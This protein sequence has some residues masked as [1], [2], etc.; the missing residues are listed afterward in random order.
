[1]T[2]RADAEAEAAA[3]M[4]ATLEDALDPFA[5]LADVFGDADD[6]EDADDGVAPLDPDMVACAAFEA[7]AGAA[8]VNA[9]MASRGK[10]AAE[11]ATLVRIEMERARH[12]SIEAELPTEYEVAMEEEAIEALRMER[13]AKSVEARAIKHAMKDA[14]AKQALAEA[15]RAAVARAEKAEKANAKGADGVAG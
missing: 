4:A 11:V 9:E 2:D 3:D 13:L 15:A 10:S 1:M 7:E 14:A 6:D 12:E 5:L 8:Y